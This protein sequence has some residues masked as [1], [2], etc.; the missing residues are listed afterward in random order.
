MLMSPHKEIENHWCFRRLAAK[1]FSLVCRPSS[2]SRLCWSICA[3]VESGY[4]LWPNLSLTG[5]NVSDIF[6]DSSSVLSLD[7]S[8]CA[9]LC[10]PLMDVLHDMQVWAVLLSTS[11]CWPRRQQWAIY[12]YHGLHWCQVCINYS[13]TF[14]IIFTHFCCFL[15]FSFLFFF[16]RN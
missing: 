9:K 7:R 11:Y 16:R 8:F 5:V 6:V 2:V 10:R 14:F 13:S 4:H 1:C 12:M 3:I 15:V